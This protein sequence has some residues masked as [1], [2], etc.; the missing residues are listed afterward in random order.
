M[1]ITT[2][3][4]ASSYGVPV[5][6]ADDGTLMDT[7]PGIRAIRE[8]LGMSRAQLGKA[9]GVSARTVE[10]WEQGKDVP[11]AKRLYMLGSLLP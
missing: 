8:S 5:I 7:G 9:L 1:K 3:H 6:L 10:A 4:S 11:A 2:D